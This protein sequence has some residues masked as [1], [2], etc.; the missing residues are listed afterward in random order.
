ML[1]ELRLYQTLFTLRIAIQWSPLWQINP[2]QIIAK[3]E[4]YLNAEMGTHL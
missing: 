2:S 1:V 3:P 4:V